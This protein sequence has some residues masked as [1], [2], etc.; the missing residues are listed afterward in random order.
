[1]LRNSGDR[2]LDEVELNV[3]Y[4]EADGKTPHWVD[5]AATKP[6]RASF[7]KTWPVLVNTALGGE[8]GTP[9]KPGGTPA[10]SVDLPLSYDLDNNDVNFAFAGIVTA[11]RFSK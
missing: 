8:I 6:G 9:L 1:M 7:S 4:L 11:L 5:Q 3:V 2:S 10:F